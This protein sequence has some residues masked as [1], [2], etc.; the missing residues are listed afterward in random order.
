MGQVT[1]SGLL[2]R[3]RGFGKLPGRPGIWIC[4]VVSLAVGLAGA[5]QAADESLEYQ[6]KAVFLLN[7]TKFVEWT[8][9]EFGAQ[10]SPMEI[11]I[12]GDDPFGS[13][14]D[15]IVEGEV[16]N[17][18]KVAAQRIKQAPPPKS[19]QILFVA[20]SEKDVSKVLAGLGP[21]VLTVGEGDGFMRDGGMIAFVIENRR[22]R[23]EINQAAAENAGIKLSS[24]LL[25]VAKSIQ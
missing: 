12:L 1:R 11:C 19:C 15:R 10:N 18:R 17:G 16:V 23:F 13:T 25:N 5:C 21:G 22:V 2:R 8:A 6:V 4:L 9:G 7:F 20:K 24:R 14:L 3:N